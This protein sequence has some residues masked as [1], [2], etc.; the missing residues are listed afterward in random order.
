VDNGNVRIEAMYPFK[1][2]YYNSSKINKEGSESRKEITKY[3]P[4]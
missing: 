2:S 1:C 4:D 3:T